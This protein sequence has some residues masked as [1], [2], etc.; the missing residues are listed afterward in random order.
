MQGVSRLQLLNSEPIMHTPEEP[1]L[2]AY[3]AAC[4]KSMVP[5]EVAVG[6]GGLQRGG[7]DPMAPGGMTLGPQADICLD[8]LVI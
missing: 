5:P 6:G 2:Q 7:R 4:Q 8:A 1:L 3:V